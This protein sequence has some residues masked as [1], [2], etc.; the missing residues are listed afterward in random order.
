LYKSDTH[1]INEVL[2]NFDE[3][4]YSTK[5]P[6]CTICVQENYLIFTNNEV[7]FSKED[8]TNF[9]SLGSSRKNG[10]GIGMKSIFRITDK[11]FVTSNDFQFQLSCQKKNDEIE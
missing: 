3:N 11:I 7:G 2:E 6:N 4:T 9:C 1:F 8:V 5:S 10:K